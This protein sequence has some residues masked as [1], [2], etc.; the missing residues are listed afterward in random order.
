[1]KT[2]H[3]IVWLMCINLLYAQ[4]GFLPHLEHDCSRYKQNIAS[5][6]SPKDI[7]QSPLLHCYDVKFYFLDLKVENNTVD[8][9][10]NVLIDAQVVVSELDTFALELLDEL[11]IDSIFINGLQQTFERNNNEVFVMLDNPLTQGEKFSCR[12][13][14]HGT[15]PTGG[16]FRGISTKY[17]TVWNKHVT[18]TLSE[19]F[20]ARQWWP[21]KQVLTD[22]A[23]SV[24]VFITTSAE[25]K[26]GS[27]GLL[28]KLTYLPD[29]KV[30]YEWKS[31]YPI[32]Y[33]LI[34]FA[35][36]EYQEYN[37]YAK[38]VNFSGDSL[39]IQ[40]YIYD[41]PGCLEYYKQGIDNTIAFVEL[42]SE[43]FSDYPFSEE[44][45]GHC[46]AGL[47]G[48]MEHQTMTTLGNFSFSLVAHELGHMW[49]GNY[50]TCSDWSNIWINE[51]FATYTDY[52]A[53]EM[54]AGGPWPGIWRNNVHN[55]I[56]SEPGGSVYV[57]EEE[58]TYD[59]VGRIFSSRLTYWKGAL[60]L[61]MIRF[62]LQ[63][64]ELFFQ[65]LKNF[66][67]KYANGS[68]STPDFVEVLNETSGLDF[69]EFF[70]QWYYGEGY[71]I[72]SINFKQTDGLLELKSVQIS[73][74]PAVTP[75]FK[76]NMPYKLFF[77]DG[78]D[79]TLILLQENNDMV[80]SV[81]VEKII[82]SIQVDPD[83]WV[84]KKVESIIGISE[85]EL[86]NPFSVSPNPVKDKLIVRSSGEVI[87]KILICDLFGNRLKEYN[88]MQPISSLDVSEL[89]PGLF[90]IT[91]LVDEERFT[92]K[93][94]K[95]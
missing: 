88:S 12:V 20:N 8:I 82:D 51:G 83:K 73:S 72:Y 15:P 17:D 43:L 54:V 84:L 74:M 66:L 5:H 6:L 93:F 38:P 53:T 40:N 95:Q 94:I 92:L 63:D 86:N 22:K 87:D 62:E 85:N 76:M 67:A 91:M 10:G 13:F 75:F 11:I 48:G 65:V 58:V 41:S 36:A 64:D 35:V 27:I 77:E 90:F 28:T 2:L 9:A 47:G 16:S 50:V 70:E 81:P 52:L 32:V 61:H 21:T 26:A 49:F 71:P 37:I 56:M 42:F 3:L 29:N 14:Y 19:P 33:Y 25:N 45:Y 78:T 31:K 69:N 57:P 24:W 59:N 23:D 1:M 18:W 4:D 44:K 34:S 46:L 39:I 7:V 80:F 79:S 89:S 60:I 68:A 55:F 30:R